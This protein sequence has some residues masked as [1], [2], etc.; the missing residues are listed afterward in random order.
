MPCCSLP[1]TL[2]QRDYAVRRPNSDRASAVRRTQSAAIERAK[3]LQPGSRPVVER[4]RFTNK[5]KSDRWW[6]P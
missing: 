6:K 4:V 2:A 3:E 1:L 5:A